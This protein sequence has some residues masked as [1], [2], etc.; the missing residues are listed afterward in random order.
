[1]F[2]TTNHTEATVKPINSQMEL[3]D[4]IDRLLEYNWEDEE[5]DYAEHEGDGDSHIFATMT[6][7]N[8]WVRSK[9]N[10]HTGGI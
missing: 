1:M 9:R 6:I 5:A 7:L 10:K 4:A 8:D 2:A 3:L